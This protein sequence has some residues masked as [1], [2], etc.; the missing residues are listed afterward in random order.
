M[1]TRIFRGRRNL[2]DGVRNAD[3]DY[4]FQQ[5]GGAGSANSALSTGWYL[6]GDSLSIS[7][8]TPLPEYPDGVLGYNYQILA[9]GTDFTWDAAPGRRITTY[10]YA[11]PA[12]TPDKYNMIIHLGTNDVQPASTEVAYKAAYQQ[13]IDDFQADGYVVHAVLPY[14]AEL[15][16]PE[17]TDRLDLLET[18][19]DWTREVCALN[20]IVP[21]DF[22][23]NSTTD[24]LHPDQAGHDVMRT[25]FWQNMNAAS[26][27]GGPI[28]TDSPQ[29]QVINTALA[30]TGNT[31]LVSTPTD[32]GGGNFLSIG[33]F[34]IVSDSGIG[35]TDLNPN[36]DGS[37]GMVWGTPQTNSF[38]A[39]AG[40]AYAI[41]VTSGP[42]TITL[43]A[44]PDA[45]DVVAFIH[46]V[47]DIETNNITL[48]PGTSEIRGDTED[49]LVTTTWT[50]CR[51][52][53]TAAEGWVVG[54][55]SFGGSKGEDSTVA[56]PQGPAG[57]DGTDGI[58]GAQG[59]QGPTGPEGP[60]GPQ[61]PQ[62]TA[63]ADG[64][65]GDITAVDGG[66]ASSIYAQSQ[67]IIGG[68]A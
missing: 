49:V 41:D 33:P 54:E 14:Y 24:L 34:G 42:V 47:G 6:I 56:G 4:N 20:D 13:I 67:Q 40:Y 16:E 22:Y 28:L 43:P 12:A 59:I 57:A 9:G 45:G 68:G 10:T 58:D 51:L 31:A 35:P 32:G 29:S 61:G 26:L 62:G 5:V 39:V 65:D 48:N 64:A 37:D 19:R 3:L 8:G 30:I 23:Y 17:W 44:S 53:Y 25:Q 7:D 52:R 38:T 27:A 36:L 50:S 46:T 66:T 1:A 11:A 15:F 55:T 18:V 60:T 2:R 21:W 63:G